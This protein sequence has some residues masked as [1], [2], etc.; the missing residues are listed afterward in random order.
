[1][2]R[3]PLLQGGGG[4]D[5]LD[6][7]GRDDI[8]DQAEGEKVPGTLTGPNRANWHPALTVMLHTPRLYKKTFGP[9]SK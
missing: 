1:M 8:L 7:V 9:I 6:L 3:K 4:V 2:K 5:L